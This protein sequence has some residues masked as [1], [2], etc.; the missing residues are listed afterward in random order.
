MEKTTHLVAASPSLTLAQ[1]LSCQ[2]RHVP[3]KR[4]FDIVF[5]VL[6]LICGLPLFFAI[7]L[8]IC[9]TSRGK[10]IYSHERVGRGGNT[11]RCY[12]FR[13][14]YRD[15][16]IRLKNLLDSHPDLKK[17]WELTYKLKNDPR[18]TSIGLLLRK[19][20]LDE[21]PQFWNVLKGDLSVVG[22]RP[23]VKAEIRKFYGVKA[24]TVLSVRPG[25]TGLWQVRGRSDTSYE[26]RVAL[27]VMYV[28]KQSMKLD[29]QLIFKTIP[30][31]ISSRGAY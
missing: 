4:A 15:A 9:L 11:F 13:T 5:S 27:D 8:A 30:A 21:L 25:I 18:V 14:M 19:L 17:E 2:I 31:I 20:S 3:V 24:A 7:S 10:V 12:K 1:E 22:P 23:V 28:E 16:D 26:K 29:L 6:V